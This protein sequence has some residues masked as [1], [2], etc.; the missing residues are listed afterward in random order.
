M[1]AF[2]GDTR[3][4]FNDHGHDNV[5]CYGVQCVSLENDTASRTRFLV[6]D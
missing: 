6:F 4:Y 1:Y 3:P 5:A 2:F